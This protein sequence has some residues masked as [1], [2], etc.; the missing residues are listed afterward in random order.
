MLT[1]RRMIAATLAAPALRAQISYREYA[2]CLPDY[3]SSLAAAAY[4]RRNQRMAALRT[5]ADIRTYQTWTRTTF[6]RLVGTLPKRSPLNIRTVGAFERDRYRV[7]KL[8]YES[9]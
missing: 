5:P 1:R 7:E 4:A 3:L 8:V 6:N 9:R 2:R